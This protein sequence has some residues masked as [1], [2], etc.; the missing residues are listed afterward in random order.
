MI[1]LLSVCLR[2]LSDL[3]ESSYAYLLQM[4]LSIN[5]RQIAQGVT[6]AAIAAPLLRSKGVS[7]KNGDL[8]VSPASLLW[9]IVA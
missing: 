9:S 3:L 6:A 1:R 7:A 4:S 2:F 8:S 5:R